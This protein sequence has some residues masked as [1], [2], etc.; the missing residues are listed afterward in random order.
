MKTLATEFPRCKLHGCTVCE[1]FPPGCVMATANP[2]D[3][4]HALEDAAFRRLGRDITDS[5]AGHLF[6]V[7]RCCKACFDANW[8]HPAVQRLKTRAAEVAA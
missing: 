7:H 2:L 1:S 3:A 6:D 8:T 5:V 4:L